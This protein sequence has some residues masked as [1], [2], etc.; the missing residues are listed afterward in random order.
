M[1]ESVDDMRTIKARLDATT[2]QTP[3]FLEIAARSAF[4]S[5]AG[6]DTADP[7][8]GIAGAIARRRHQRL[9]KGRNSLRIGIPR[10]LAMYQTAPLFR[11]Y[12][13]SLGVRPR[14]LVYS[15]FTSPK[16]YK[17]GATRGSIDPCFPS[18]L[19]IPHVHNL[20]YVKQK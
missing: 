19:A 10:V 5:Y 8:N 20:I 17:E 15:D 1:V 13:E 6:A 3:N 14:N 18:K 11:T 4:R 16:L 2:Q 7:T 9:P 12:F